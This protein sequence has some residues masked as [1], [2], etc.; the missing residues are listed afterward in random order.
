MS[1]DNPLYFFMIVARSGKFAV[2]ARGGRRALRRFDTREEATSFALERASLH[3]VWVSVH[4]PDG[5]V[6]RLLVPNTYNVPV[7]QW[8]KWSPRQQV[9]FNDVYYTGGAQGM[10]R[11]TKAA[12]V[13]DEHW[14]VTRWNFAFEAACAAGR[15]P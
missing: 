3:G 4:K 9:V 14:A 6:D 5:M 12:P 1:V 7:R 13:P 10:M 11:H 15:A 2:R 8:K